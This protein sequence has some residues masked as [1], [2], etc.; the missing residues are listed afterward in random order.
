[1]RDA[2]RK[3]ARSGKV[4][5]PTDEPFIR[6]L[7][8]VRQRYEGKSITTRDLLQVFEEELPAPLWYEGHKSLDWFYQGWING[9]AVPRFELQSVKY[10]DKAGSTLVSGNIAQKSSAKDLVTP[11]PV[12]GVLGAKTVFV[13]QVFVDGPEVP[14]QLTAPLGTRKLV[15][16]PAA[17]LL[18]R[19]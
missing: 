19:R 16:D 3:N 1:M 11:V 6:A 15:L 10:A 12:Y 5:S 4:L 18:T 2:S 9:T 17:T 13:G 14:F 8:N 7:R